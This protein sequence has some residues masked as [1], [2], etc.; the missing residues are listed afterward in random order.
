MKNAM[1]INLIACLLFSLCLPVCLINCLPADRDEL[2]V[3]EECK[4]KDGTKGICI[5]DIEC[6]SF[7]DFLEHREKIVRCG[8]RGI[9]MVL[10]CPN[11]VEPSDIRFDLEFS[12]IL[13]EGEVRKRPEKDLR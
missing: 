2:N 5:L 3:G 7:I 9:H 12:K 6:P 1:K 8:F 13:C 4:M 10:C 11:S